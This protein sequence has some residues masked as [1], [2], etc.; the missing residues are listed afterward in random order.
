M[1]SSLLFFL[2]SV[3]LVFNHWDYEEKI[4]SISKQLQIKISNND[5]ALEVDNAIDQGQYDDARMYLD[6]AKSNQ[7]HINYKK[8]NEIIRK[9]DTQFNSMVGQLSSFSSGFIRGKGEGM[10][11]LAGAITS[12]FTVVGDV[13]DLS[14]EFEKY[15]KG[16]EVNELIVVLSGVGIGLTALTVGSLGS[17]AP[18]KAGVS[19]I[20]FATK[21]QRVTVHFQKMLLK[22]G[23]KVFDWTD[24]K[25]ISKQS[26]SI[27]SLRMAAKKAYHPEAMKPLQTIAKRV[28]RIRKYSSA[29]DTVHLLKY[30]ES[31]DDLIH[32]EVLVVKQG[33]KAKGLMK[34]LGKGAIRTVRVLR[35]TAGL[36]FSIIASILSGFVSIALFL[37]RRVV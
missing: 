2:G 20:K 21:A 37:A 10:A 34:L 33:S 9:E 26:K 11:S 5:I 13:R 30:I 19:M 32:L 31:S 8:Y 14:K 15:N 17:A 4:L 27:R 23:R 7:Y 6:I 3:L 24:F 36:F 25:K 12:D 18:V 22:L 28:N 29:A 1:F 35:K 16:E